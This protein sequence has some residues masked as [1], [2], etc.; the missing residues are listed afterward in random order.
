MEVVS[1]A[2]FLLF[3][4]RSIKWGEISYSFVEYTCY[5]HTIHGHGGG[6]DYDDDAIRFLEKNSGLVLGLPFCAFI[7]LIPSTWITSYEMMM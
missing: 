5:I 6:G 3:K 2:A 1:S 4:M 7:R